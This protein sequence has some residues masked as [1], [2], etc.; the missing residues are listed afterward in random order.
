[1]GAGALSAK[2]VHFP[3]FRANQMIYASL[4]LLMTLAS[5]CEVLPHSPGKK[6]VSAVESFDEGDLLVSEMSPSVSSRPKRSVIF[7]MVEN[8][9]QPKFRKEIKKLY[10]PRKTPRLEDMIWWHL[11]P[12]FKLLYDRVI[13]IP[14]DKLSA[15]SLAEAID[16]AESLN[17]E[18]DLVLLTHGYPNHLSASQGAD[19]ISWEDID[20]F[21]GKLSHLRAVYMQSC[22]GSSLSQDWLQAGAQFAIASPG[23]TEN[24]FFY[25]VFVSSLIHSDGDVSVAYSETA[26]N[27]EDIIEKTPLY[28]EFI[29]AFFKESPQSYFRTLDMPEMLTA[30]TLSP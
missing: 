27:L 23:L 7:A 8:E 11:A 18:Y 25:D 2:K 17:S 3:R 1:M 9:F 30:T 29:S 16:Y 12:R 24:F 21:K 26:K 20:Q 6:T 10:F 5:G 28:K 4:V 13:R 14:Y 19:F 22:F 15:H